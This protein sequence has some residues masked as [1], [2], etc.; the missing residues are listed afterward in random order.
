MLGARQRRSGGAR[1]R[2]SRASCTPRPARSTARRRSCRSTKSTRSVGQSPYSASKIGADKVME[3]C[4]RSFELPVA[5]VRPFNTFGP[6]QSARAV[7]PT[8]ISQAL[9]GDA[10]RL[11]S[12]DPRRDLT[13][14]GDTVHGFLAAATSDAAVGRTV[15]LGTGYDVTIGEIVEL[16]GDIVGRQLVVELDEQRVRP[17]ASEVMRLISDPSLAKELMGW[18]PTVDLRTGPRAHR[19]VDRRQPGSLPRRRVHDLMAR[20][21]SSPRRRDRGRGRHRGGRGGLPLRLALDGPPDG[22][23]R[24]GVRRPTSARRTPSRPPT[25]PPRCTSPRSPPGSARATRS[26]SRR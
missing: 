19:R 22:G 23:V 26:S 16:V 21:A 20:L 12:L 2:A 15:Q 3:A 18:E 6:R 1:T 24:A 11:G 5:I 4:H 17:P 9:A 8:I 13:Y 25:A 14:V 7:I 10:L